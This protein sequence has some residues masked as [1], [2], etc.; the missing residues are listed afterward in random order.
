[1]LK[2]SRSII[3][4]SIKGKLITGF[5]L[6]IILLA[7]LAWV[8]VNSLSVMNDRLN[9]IVDI[10]AEK[11]K[12]AARINQGAL[13]FSRAEKNIILAKS[14]S[15]MDAFAAL[16]DEIQDDMKSRRLL[17][18][19][20]VND[21]DKKIVDEF[22][23][24]WDQY[25]E[26]NKDVRKLARLNSNVRAKALSKGDSR[27][28]YDK[29][30]SAIS[31]IVSNNEGSLD[32]TQSID[33]ARIVGKRIKLA[34]RIN[35]NLMEIQRGEKNIILSSTEQ[36][37]EGFLKVIKQVN[38]ELNERLVILNRTVSNEGRYQVNDFKQAY[39][40][41]YVLHK[42]VLGITR[43]NGNHLAFELSNGKG[44]ELND[45]AIDIMARIVTKTEFDMAKNSSISD[46]NY[47]VARNLILSI[48]AFGLLA[49]IGIA[50][51]I[52]NSV[53]GALQRLLSNLQA[54]ADGSGDLTVT[55][56]D[57]S[58]DET[59][60]VARAFNIF[61]GI[62]QTKFQ[63]IFN[64][65]YDGMII[66]DAQGSIDAFNPAAE[67]IFGFTPQEV[68][69]KNV[70]I[71]MPEPYRSDHDSYLNNHL[72]TGKKKVI[73]IGREVSGRCKD[74]SVFPMDLAIS[75]MQISGKPMFVGLVR[76]ITERKQHEKDIKLAKLSAESANRMKSEFLANMSHE[77]RTP[78]NAI[79]G[80]S[81]ML[82]E[83]A[84]DDGNVQTI[85]DLNKICTS[86]NHLLKLINEVLDLAKI[87]AGQV[88]LLFESFPVFTFVQEISMLTQPQM[89][90]NSNHFK[91]ICDENI[92]EF[93]GD[94]DRLRQVLLNLLSNA[95]KFT[96]KG[97]VTLNVRRDVHQ[98]NQ[99]LK[100]SV[101]DTGIG[102]TSEQLDKVFIPFVQAD[103]S[104][105]RE[106]GGTGLGLTISKD[107][108]EIMGGH[109]NAQSEVG[110]GSTFTVCIPV[111][112][113]LL[114]HQDRGSK[115]PAEYVTT[116]DIA[117]YTSG[118]YMEEG[119]CV[120]V[121]DDD[122]KARDLIIRTL[123]RDGFSIAAASNGE[124][125]LAL[126]KELRP[127]CI[128]LDIMMPGMSGW[129]LI[130]VLKS[131][132]ETNTI[133]VIINTIIDK[134]RLPEAEGAIAYL[135]KP[136]QKTE[137]LNLLNGLAPEQGAVDVLIVE[138]ES[139]I[140]EL[141]AR[142][143]SDIGWIARSCINGLEALIDVQQKMPDVILLD[144]MMPKMD[145]FQF[146]TELRKI[147]E[148]YKVPVVILTAKDLT[149]Q[150]EILLSQSTKL[151]IRKGDLKNMNELLPM[152][153][154]FMR[155]PNASEQ[156]S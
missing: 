149:G 115:L 36:E 63:G 125:G 1:M 87:E 79:I 130:K 72:T 69:G 122:D 110:K 90:N 30:S 76:N 140:R 38:K 148:G 107:I 78:L 70:K 45:R 77:L 32:E 3:L 57:S 14:Q 141:V 67:R 52:S 86:G 51:Y 91:I 41:Y 127:L 155:R 112:S 98:G 16:S 43:E 12:L 82:K 144:L 85:D 55:I 22:A 37:L 61:A 132:P 147:P 8:S 64:N 94:E 35:L 108:C 93:Y 10:S 20:L 73:G 134:H 120:L 66:I 106:F 96:N 17:L 83:D 24:Y 56:D 53:S 139:D 60:D 15:E 5:S 121:V 40:E 59:G 26:T 97:Q 118:G 101:S 9:N 42:E 74:G 48:A 150:E 50:F 81:E 27:D 6:L 89:D 152:V 100:F 109:I 116:A 65:V 49:G 156:Q 136:F 68:L 133:P 21:D 46:E 114:E 153:R 117:P 145:G 34:A 95:A 137:L 28:A 54:L 135:S 47:S 128:I 19:E 151:V 103:A 105:T 111:D 29:A 143:I 62:A 75:P 154:R 58:K 142:Q 131:S 104:T 11:V 84:E 44:R 113:S 18:R 25:I 138:D 102:M 31:S 146:L 123:E 99:Q 2:N 92:G 7:V 126:A 33:D 39:E 4:H 119:E 13:A 124:Q 23:I 129:E 80:Y 88:E 71:L